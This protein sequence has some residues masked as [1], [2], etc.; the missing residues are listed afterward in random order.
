[1]IGEELFCRLPSNWLS[2]PSMCWFEWQTMVGGFLAVIAAVVSIHFLRKQIAS[3]EKQESLRVNRHHLAVRTTLPLTLSG[4]C[5][6][7][8]KMLLELDDAKSEIKKVGQDAYA[9]KFNGPPPPSEHIE[10]L[11]EVVQSTDEETVLKSVA[12]IIREMQ[13]LWS[14][15]EVL[16]N[17]REMGVNV[18]ISRN[19]DEYIIQLQR[20]MH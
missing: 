3:S 2:D 1:M 4:L 5:A 9:G 6:C 7:L 12:E 18:G 17:K 13:T 8:R 15:A 19:L 11:K 14:R 16:N 20:F 10:E